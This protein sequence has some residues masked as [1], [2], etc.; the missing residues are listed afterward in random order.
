MLRLPSRLKNT[1]IRL[2]QTA[3]VILVLNVLL[4]V[5]SLQPA[6]AESLR[7][8]G[9]YGMSAE[10]DLLPL[11]E[12]SAFARSSANTEGF[13][14]R[15]GF[16]FDPASSSWKRAQ[17]KE[18]SIKAVL[19]PAFDDAAKVFYLAIEDD[20]GVPH[21]TSWQSTCTFAR[22]SDLDSSHV[23]GLVAQG[24]VLVMIRSGSIVRSTDAGISFLP[25]TLDPA[26]TELTVTG[27]F[28]SGQSDNVFYATTTRDYNS[29]TELYR[30]LDAGATWT[31][32]R[33]GYFSIYVDPSTHFIFLFNYDTNYADGIPAPSE[34]SMNKG[35]TWA[36]L[37]EF[38]E[39]PGGGKF[40]RVGDLLY[41]GRAGDMHA[42]SD[43]GD[44][45]SD[46][47]LPGLP[48]LALGAARI[49]AS[50]SI[51]FSLSVDNGS[52]WRDVSTG[53]E[54][55]SVEDVAVAPGGGKL[56]AIAGDVYKSSNPR[57]AQP[58]WIKV[59]WG[60]PGSSIHV[61][62]SK[63]LLLSRTDIFYRSVNNGRTWRETYGMRGPYYNSDSGFVSI[64]SRHVGTFVRPFANGD[65]KSFLLESLDDGSTWKRK[66][67]PRNASSMIGSDGR[68]LMLTVQTDR[69]VSDVYEYNEGRWKKLLHHH[70]I[71]V[72]GSD[73][74]NRV[75]AVDTDVNGSV[76]AS[77]DGG[78]HWKK[79]KST[80]PWSAGKVV[81]V[82]PSRPDELYIACD[83]FLMHSTNGGR[84][85]KTALEIP[86]ATYDMS[87]MKGKLIISTLV[88]L[89]MV[90][91]GG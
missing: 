40:A 66:A 46:V 50:A 79:R 83:E 10:S 15:F 45:W 86:A 63:A 23:S 33:T 14:S 17:Y 8:L 56:Y 36:V 35:D 68:F 87:F 26:E 12:G 11:P 5:L 28:S 34:R 22:V 89:Y 20:E 81:A 76:Y 88:G 25:V 53:L 37:P 41:S 51:G 43:N 64:S 69:M 74:A 3:L 84:S 31:R 54:G 32:I 42:S 30:S 65:G 13:Y 27:I 55:V 48:M 91:R 49:L 52:S 57:S 73:G 80:L 16:C 61:T 2:K 4:P 70:G 90:E 60:Y 67:A 62:P 72:I 59:S 75:Y 58:V 29:D 38:P 78:L 82:N 7:N 9:I 77:T 71:L 39:I 21:L 24:G 18:G 85:W 44:T 1:V 19:S 6:G 47:N